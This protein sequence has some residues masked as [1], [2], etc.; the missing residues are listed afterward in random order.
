MMMMTKEDEDAES[1]GRVDDAGLT[2]KMALMML[3]PMVL[4]MLC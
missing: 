3:M 4:M 1:F 2:M